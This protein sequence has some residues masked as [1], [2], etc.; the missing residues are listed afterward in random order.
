MLTDTLFFV[1]QILRKPLTIWGLAISF[2]WISLFPARFGADINSLIM[3]LERDQSTAH[4]TALYFRIFQGITVNGHAIWLGSLICISLLAISLE[5]LLRAVSKNPIV[6]TRLRILLAYSPFFGVFGMTLDHQLFTTIGFLNC[7]AFSI[8]QKVGLFPAHFQTAR[9]SRNLWLIISFFFLL[10]TFQGMVISFVFAFMFFRKR[11]SIPI[12][13]AVLAFGLF[14]SSILQVSTTRTEFSAAVSDL[15]LVPLLGDIKCVV[16]HPKVILTASETA[17]LSKV[18]G[19]ENWKNP[20]SCIVADNSFFALHGSSRYQAEIVKTWLS[21][22]LRYP[23][24]V[25]VAHLQRSSMALPPPFF[26]GQPNMVPTNDLEPAGI[27]LSVEL[28][29]WSELFKTSIDNENL[30]EIRPKVVKLLEPLPLLAAFF[31]NQNSEFWGWGGIWFLIA[32]IVLVLRRREGSPA[33]EFSSLIPLLVLSMFLFVMSPASACRYVMPQ[34]IYG[35]VL[36]SEYLLRK[37]ETL[38][39]RA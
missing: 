25:L 18:G 10:M 22:S 7:L 34:I 28:H 37:L 1:K 16:Q 9:W 17:T 21:L 38:K 12:S 19:L 23:Q 35:I 26:R 13:T 2:Y 29:Q 33:V 8:N 15:R 31:F 20:K 32:L 4:W 11:I 27:D 39:S 5:N 6:L 30:K 14:S 24:L 36:S 3:L